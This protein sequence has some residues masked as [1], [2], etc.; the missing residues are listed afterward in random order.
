MPNEGFRGISLKT[1]LVDELDQFVIEYPR[2][3][4]VPEFVAESVRIR[5]E[6]IRKQKKR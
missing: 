1:E 5:M 6:Q 4:S 2:Y 3:R